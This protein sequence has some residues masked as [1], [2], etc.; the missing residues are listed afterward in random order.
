MISDSATSMVC[1]TATPS[2]SATAC[3]SAGFS[4]D[5]SP[6]DFSLCTWP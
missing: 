3:S 5:T 4:E 1:V 6:L 2:R